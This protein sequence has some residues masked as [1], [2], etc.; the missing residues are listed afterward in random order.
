M[1][2]VLDVCVAFV[3]VVVCVVHVV[4]VVSLGILNVRIGSSHPRQS[5]FMVCGRRGIVL[6]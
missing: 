2:V 5:G 6:A 3:V 4:Y 1:H